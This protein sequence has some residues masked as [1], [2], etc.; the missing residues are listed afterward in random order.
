MDAEGNGGGDADT[1]VTPNAES[2]KKATPKRKRGPNKPKDP[3]APPAAKRGKKG[4]AAADK[5][6]D[7]NGGAAEVENDNDAADAQLNYGENGSIFG[8]DA[9]VKGSYFANKVPLYLR[10]SGSGAPK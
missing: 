9:E 6:N 10:S 4:G 5:K 7:D 8:G 1:E 2:P 3:N